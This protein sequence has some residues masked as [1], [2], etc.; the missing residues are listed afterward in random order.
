MSLGN[1]KLVAQLS[2][3]DMTA[4]LSHNLKYFTTT[5]SEEFLLGK[6]ISFLT[7]WVVANETTE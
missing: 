3:R 1:I 4:T 6:K 7:I 2:G 5:N